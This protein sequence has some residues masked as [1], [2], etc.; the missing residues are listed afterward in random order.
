MVGTRREIAYAI[1]ALLDG[2]TGYLT[3]QI[4]RADGGGSIA[5]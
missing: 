4:V 3:G 2:D 1:Y 5:A